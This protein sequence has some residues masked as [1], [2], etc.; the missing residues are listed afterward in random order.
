ME[1]KTVNIL[2]I[3]IIAS[4]FLG[5]FGMIGYLG[6]T[7]YKKETTCRKYNE[8]N[9]T[10]IKE[11]I[12]DESISVDYGCPYPF[13]AYSSK[14]GDI[15]MVTFLVE[16]GAEIEKKFTYKSPK[17]RAYKIT[18]TP[19]FY[20]IY[21]KYDAKRIDFPMEISEDFIACL[22]LLVENGASLDTPCGREYD[23]TVNDSLKTVY[24]NES[25]DSQTAREIIKLIDNKLL[26]DFEAKY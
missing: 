3:S 6:I 14:I 23:E 25:P 13:L 17:M 10:A 16:N 24:R 12:L 4:I 22:A 8:G 18:H 5:V 2:A 26:N 21:G 15:D 7:T 1:E 11:M 19:L 20:A 9:T